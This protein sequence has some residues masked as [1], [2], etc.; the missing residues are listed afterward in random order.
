MANHIEAIETFLDTDIHG[1]A[2]ESDAGGIFNRQ[3]PEFWSPQHQAWLMT[4]DT[5]GAWKK[6]GPLGS[7]QLDQ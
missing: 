6:G 2:I 3:Q 7:S 4:D 5:A 1:A